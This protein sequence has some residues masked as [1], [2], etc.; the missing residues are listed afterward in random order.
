MASPDLKP[1]QYGRKYGNLVGT[2]VLADATT[3]VVA[4]DNT[5]P[6]VVIGPFDATGLK[7]SYGYHSDYPLLVK[8]FCDSVNPDTTGNFRVKVS[9]SLGD[10]EIQRSNADSFSLTWDVR[11]W[12]SLTDA[13]ATVTIMPYTPV[14]SVSMNCVCGLATDYIDRKSEGSYA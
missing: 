1:Y 3:P 8:L 11:D 5:A 9:G 12:V 13:D 7:T 10:A 14:T 2:S 4:V 6:K